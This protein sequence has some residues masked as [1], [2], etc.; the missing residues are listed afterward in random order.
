MEI[1]SPTSDTYTYGTL[2]T[3]MYQV[4]DVKNEHLH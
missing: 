2:C 1:Q 4:A 3:S